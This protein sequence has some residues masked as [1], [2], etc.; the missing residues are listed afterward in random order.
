[1]VDRKILVVDDNA[2]YC[3]GIVDFLEMEGFD[4]IAVHD[5]YK[6]LETIKKERFDMVLMD[7]RMPGMDGVE[8]FQKLQ[9][10][11]LILLLF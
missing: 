3:E 1:M 4:A 10:S 2:D 6:A 5:G 11:H 8:T 7:I 9:N